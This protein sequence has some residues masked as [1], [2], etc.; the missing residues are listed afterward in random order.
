MD[1]AERR[2]RTQTIIERR[3]RLRGKTSFRLFVEPPVELWRTAYLYK[4]RVGNQARWTYH[5]WL[6]KPGILR[7]HN[8]AHGRCA[9]CD[10]D[11]NPRR[12]QPTLAFELESLE[13]ASQ[14]ETDSFRQSDRRKHRKDTKRWCRGK[15]GVPH[16]A[17][18]QSP[19]SGSQ[20]LIC[21]TCGKHLDSCWHRAWWP[22]KT[23]CR[24]PIGRGPPTGFGFQ[25]LLL[26]AG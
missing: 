14:P 4:V 3:V 10:H 13:S 22:R 15:K 16:L 11:E 26:R 20:V 25:R 8:G 1:R 17:H 6:S 24:C 12:D 9:T 18:W 21:S 7:K 5:G 19:L 23:K 2:R